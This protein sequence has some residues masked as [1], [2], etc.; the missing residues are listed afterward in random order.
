MLVNT[1]KSEKYTSN[2]EF[3]GVIRWK[4]IRFVVVCD[5]IMR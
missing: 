4:P 1:G 3:A 5:L 2:F